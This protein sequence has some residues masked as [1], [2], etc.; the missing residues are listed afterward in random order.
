V[1]GRD[2]RRVLGRSKDGV[3]MGLSDAGARGAFLLDCSSGEAP[4]LLLVLSTVR[5]YLSSTDA[6]SLDS[7][8][9]WIYEVI[10]DCIFGEMFSRFSF[11][12]GISI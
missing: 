11:R 3:I 7:I 5:D 2:S 6:D 9:I 8:R 12:V 4:G 1:W 10:G